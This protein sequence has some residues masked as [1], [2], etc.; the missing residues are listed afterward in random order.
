MR[1]K[2][3]V[4]EG[5]PGSW[6]WRLMAEDGEEVGRSACSFASPLAAERSAEWARDLAS[7]ATV[8]RSQEGPPEAAPAAPRP[9]ARPAPQPAR[10]TEPE[11][12]EQS[13]NMVFRRLVQAS[14]AHTQS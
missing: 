8:T 7:A 2:F 6:L 4:V 1:P 13:M 9:E 14:R 3:V 10:E 5:Q 12:A 11:P